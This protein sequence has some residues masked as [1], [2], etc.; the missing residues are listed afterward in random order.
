MTLS[1]AGGAPALSSVFDCFTDLVLP[2]HAGGLP[3]LALVSERA[4]RVGYPCGTYGPQETHRL[5]RTPPKHQESWGYECGC[6]N[7]RSREIT[8]RSSANL[9]AGCC[10]PISSGRHSFPPDVHT[11]S[12]DQTMGQVSLTRGSPMEPSFTAMLPSPSP[13]TGALI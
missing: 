9:I 1:A 10:V 11:V 8:S 7:P 12:G 5:N 6:E 13:S 3:K 4:D 2:L